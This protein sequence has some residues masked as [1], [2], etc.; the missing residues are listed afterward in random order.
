MLSFKCLQMYNLS[1]DKQQWFC[2]NCRNNTFPFNSIDNRDILSE[3]FNSNELCSC[4]DVTKDLTDYECLE[5]IAELNLNKLDL[6][7][8]Q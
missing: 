2:N 6:N 3:N 7:Q 5:T 8:F 1:T 4:Y